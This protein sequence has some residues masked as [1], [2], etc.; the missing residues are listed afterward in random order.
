[1]DDFAEL[2]FEGASAG[3]DNY[4]KVYDPLKEKAKKLPNPIKKSRGG[5]QNRD[6]YDDDDDDASYDS[7]DDYHS[8]RRTYTDRDGGRRHRDSRGG[9][10]YVEE[11]YERRSGRAKSTGRDG[12]GGGRGLDRRAR[13]K[14][15]FDEPPQA[16]RQ[17]NLSQAAGRCITRTP[18]LP[19]H[20]LVVANPSA[21]RLS[22][23]SALAVGSR[24]LNETWIDVATMIAIDLVV[25]ATGEKAIAT[26]IEFDA[27]SASN[28]T[29]LLVVPKLSP[30]MASCNVC[31]PAISVPTFQSRTFAWLPAMATPPAIATP[32]DP[33][34]RV[35]TMLVAVANA[36]RHRPAPHPPPSVPRPKMSAASRR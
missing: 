36:H 22:Q 26:T 33:L 7:Y 9:G 16:M 20:R 23:H 24:P 18:N 32:P 31:P 29:I 2:A 19:S 3:I 5:Q 14:S 34:S 15:P 28:M 1:M 17:A 13:S 11:S 8:P 35:V 25:A 12:I 21:N 30:I 4:E 10:A 6:Q 27:K